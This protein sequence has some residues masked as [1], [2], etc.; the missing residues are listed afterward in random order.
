MYDGDVYY[1]YREQIFSNNFEQII[2][3]NN[4]KDSMK[5]TISDQSKGRQLFIN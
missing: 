1:N 2:Y 5:A 3:E 4:G